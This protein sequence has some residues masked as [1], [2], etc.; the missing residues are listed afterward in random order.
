MAGRTKVVPQR[1]QGK[2]V[3][4]K[5]AF[6]WIQP[7]APIKHPAASKNK[8]RIYLGQ[9]DVEAELSGVGATVSFFVYSDG[10]GLGAMNVRPAAAQKSAAVQQTVKKAQPAPVQKALQATAKAQPRKSNAVQ[11]A[12]NKMRGASSVYSAVSTASTA[13]APK[14]MGQVNIKK[15]GAVQRAKEKMAAA[16]APAKAGVM[17]GSFTKQPMKGSVTK[18]PTTET[19]AKANGKT[20]TRTKVM[21]NRLT[22]KVKEWKGAFGWIVPDQSISHPESKKHGGKLYLAHEDVEEELSGV[23]ASVSFFVYSDGNGLGAMN[24]RTAA[25]KS[26]SL[27]PNK[28]AGTATS[29]PKL[30]GM[31]T[32]LKAAATL[33]ASAKKAAAKGTTKSNLKRTRLTEEP[34]MGE[35][36]Q[37]KGK[38]GWIKPSESVD[39]IDDDKDLYCTKE[40]LVEG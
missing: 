32:M 21:P 7:S 26:K 15:S 9:E 12:V 3:E 29:K 38:I 5:G 4:W 37:F 34:V 11:E 10:K 33:K 20:G 40:D 13:A 25:A 14:T 39:G 18:Q 31:A 17:K 36:V 30:G 28:F 27:P 2:V 35:I 24:V 22:G 1:V 8:G 6:G 19:V 16:E 23:G